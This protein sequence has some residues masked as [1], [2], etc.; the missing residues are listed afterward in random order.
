MSSQEQVEQSSDVGDGDEV[1]TTVY[2]YQIT[3]TDPEYNVKVRA[4]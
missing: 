4:N 2:R 1:M 3:E